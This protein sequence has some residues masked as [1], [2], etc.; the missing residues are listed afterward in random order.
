MRYFCLPRIIPVKFFSK[1]DPETGRIHQ[2]A[3]L[4]EPWYVPTT[5]WSRWG[6]E[7]L[8]TRIAGGKLPGDDGMTWMPKGFLMEDIGPQ[9]TMGQGLAE[10][11]SLAD[12]KTKKSATPANPFWTLK[13]AGA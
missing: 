8:L 6:P 12:P 11:N 10:T 9:K 7:A 3:Y 2:Y 13:S 1:P 5:F 4:K